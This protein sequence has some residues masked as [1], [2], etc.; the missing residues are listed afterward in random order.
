MHRLFVEARSSNYIL[1]FDEADSLFGSRTDVKGSNDRYAN[2]QVQG[3]SPGP[4]RR[5][6]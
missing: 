3:R 6:R 5:V 1:L 2:R 4:V